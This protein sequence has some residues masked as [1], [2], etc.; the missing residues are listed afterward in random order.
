MARSYVAAE[1][2]VGAGPIIG[3]VSPAVAKKV[4]EQ[5]AIYKGEMYGKM[6]DR[7]EGWPSALTREVELRRSLA[8]DPNTKFRNE[9]DDPDYELNESNMINVIKNAKVEVGVLYDKFNR[10]ISFTK[11]EKERVFFESLASQM[12]GGHTIHNHP[13]GGPPSSG[14]IFAHSYYKS[15]TTKVVSAEGIY[16]VT[17]SLAN[18]SGLKEELTA[19][20]MQAVSRA[21]DWAK[22]V[23]A[24]DLTETKADSLRA[25]R[26]AD[27]IRFEI[28]DDVAKKFEAIINKMAWVATKAE[29]ESKGLKAEFLPSRNFK[30]SQGFA[31]YDKIP[32]PPKDWIPK[33][34]YE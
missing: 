14:D 17:G 2:R 8:L 19:L 26:N 29:I 11:G 20:Q 15:A 33:S 6:A 24:K 10:L 12:E 7:R 3:L 23:L 27:D 21:Y 34:R 18:N 22:E 16:T 13:A 31:S 1:V 30:A 32:L 9:K 28:G 4:A 5:R 25:A